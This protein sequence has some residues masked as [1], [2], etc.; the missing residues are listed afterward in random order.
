[1]AWKP[2]GSRPGLPGLIDGRARTLPIFDIPGRVFVRFHYVLTTPH[3]LS[4]VLPLVNLIIMNSFSG[5]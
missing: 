4:G 5:G 3:V 2:T 1:V